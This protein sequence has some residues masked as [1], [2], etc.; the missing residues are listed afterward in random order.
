MYQEKLFIAVWECTIAKKK[1]EVQ[2][3]WARVKEKSIPRKLL[4]QGDTTPQSEEMQA[5]QE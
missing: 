5:L 4:S 1:F 3:D 2:D